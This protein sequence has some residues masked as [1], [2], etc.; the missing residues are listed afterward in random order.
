MVKIT[1]LDENGKHGKASISHQLIIFLIDFFESK[2]KL[3]VLDYHENK[4]AS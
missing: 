2:H 3:E 4:I 1:N